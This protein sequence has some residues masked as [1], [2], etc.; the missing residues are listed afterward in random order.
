MDYIQVET[1]PLVQN[2]HVGVVWRVN[3][4]LFNLCDKI[5]IVTVVLTRKLKVLLGNNYFNFKPNNLST[6]FSKINFIAITYYVINT[7][8]NL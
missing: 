7:W 3:I 8:L 2:I 5:I 6:N 4:L 1:R